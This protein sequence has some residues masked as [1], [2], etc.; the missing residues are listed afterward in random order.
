VRV[1]LI[2]LELKVFDLILLDGIGMVL[3]DQSW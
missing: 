3:E 2:A 1:S